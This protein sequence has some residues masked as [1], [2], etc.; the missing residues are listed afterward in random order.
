MWNVIW[1][2]NFLITLV[3]SKRYPYLQFILKGENTAISGIQPWLQQHV[4]NPQECSRICVNLS[5]KCAYVQ[6]G[7]SPSDPTQWLCQLFDDIQ[8]LSSYLVSKLNIVL[9]SAVHE[10]HHCSDMKSQL[11][12][13]DDGLYYIT[14]NR[15]RK[16][17]FCDMTK[18]GGGWTVIQRRIDGSENF[19]RNWNDYKNGFG[20]AE[21]EYWIGNDAI[22]ELTKNTSVVM[23]IR[24]EATSF[25]GQ[26][27]YIINEGFYIESEENKY[28]LHTGT[29]IEALLGNSV[30][31]WTYHDAMKFST[32]DQD[33]DAMLENHCAM[34]Y[35]SGWWFNSCLR[36]N[37]N[38]V[39]DVNNEFPG[40]VAWM[41]W[42]GVETNLKYFSV[43][44]KRK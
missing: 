27:N 24:L 7:P 12:Y 5:L 22:H 2:I 15:N 19:N 41:N 20:S 28:L 21:G 14:F 32:Y 29:N 42:K 17:V 36:V 30:Q 11:G 23:Q 33:N 38:G 44:I 1:F 34:Y 6:Y 37:P 35:K 18:N 39:Y 3:F 4:F 26:T 9:L 43:S 16:Q 31:D 25:D 10:N 40:A 8:D 13:T